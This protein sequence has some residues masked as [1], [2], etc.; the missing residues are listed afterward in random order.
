M[1]STITIGWVR[2]VS[3]STSAPVRPLQDR[4][5]EAHRPGERRGKRE[6]PLLHQRRDARL[7]G[8][9][10]RYGHVWQQPR[11]LLNVVHTTPVTSRRGTNGLAQSYVT[12]AGV[13][14]TIVR[15]QSVQSPPDLH[16]NRL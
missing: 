12:P 3:I 8:E 9:C 11:H 14:Q 2:K 5:P 10:E 4:Q 6:D 7:P 1:P 13:A 16:C 15:G